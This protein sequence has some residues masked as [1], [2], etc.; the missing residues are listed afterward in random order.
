MHLDLPPLNHFPLAREHSRSAEMIAEANLYLSSLRLKTTLLSQ[1]QLEHMRTTDLAGFVPKNVLT[2]ALVCPDGHYDRTLTISRAVILLFIADDCV[3][4]TSE[5]KRTF[6]H[7]IENI[8]N[9][10]PDPCESGVAREIR[11]VFQTLA[12][13]STEPEYRQY[14]R[15]IR[16]WFRRVVIFSLDQGSTKSMGCDRAEV[17]P[18]HPT[19][20]STYLEMRRKN[21][22][23]YATAAL[24]RYAAGIYVSDEEL[25]DPLL[26]RCSDLGID[27]ASYEKEI[28]QEKQSTGRPTV[29]LV[30]LI[31][32]HGA[33]GRQFTTPSEVKLFIQEE[34]ERY[35]GMFHASLSTALSDMD[36]KGVPKSDHR[37][38]WLYIL[39]YIV[40]GN[41][42]WGQ[43]CGRYNLPGKPVL[44]KIIHL[45]GGGDIIEPEPACSKT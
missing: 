34:I 4:S 43:T 10:H 41:A 6:F 44:R 26:S 32:E 42:W 29:N 37:R 28:L 7:E 17:D 30:G 36:D 14:V 24:A 11:D 45:E 3:D 13:T 21:V 27:L 1:A 22:A 31:L 40:S 12:V 33:D 8:L 18:V 5:A 19:K 16:E 39:P 20:I 23:G 35:E 2:E 38:R 9:G 25:S 15:R